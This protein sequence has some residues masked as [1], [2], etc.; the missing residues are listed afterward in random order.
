MICDRIH[1]HGEGGLLLVGIIGLQLLLQGQDLL[2]PLIQAPC[3]RNHD[4]PL[5]QQQLLI[6]VYLQVAI[7]ARSC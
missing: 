5:F 1:V 7:L 2:I 4:V 3:Q 6:P